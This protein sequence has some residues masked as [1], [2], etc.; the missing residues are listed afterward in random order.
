MHEIDL[1]R[2]PATLSDC[3]REPIHMPGAILPHGVMLVLDSQSMTVLQVAGDTQGLFDLAGA[4]LIGAGIEAIFPA[5]AAARVRQLCADQNI[6]KPR[7]LLDPLLRVIADRPVDASV[8]RTGDLLVIEFEP[9]EI[10]EPYASDPLSAVQEMIEGFAASPSIADLCQKAAER[11]RRVAKYDRV[12]V[13]RFMADASGWVI[14][15]ARR[16]DMPPFLDLH[17]PATDIPQQARALYLQNWLRLITQ[18]DYEPAPLQPRLNPRTGKG[19][20]MSQAIL[21]DVSPIH[22]QYLRNMGIEAS[23]SIS[24]IVED[25]LWGLIACHHDSPRRLP[26]HL[27]AVCEL[28]GAMFSLQ[29]EACERTEMFGARLTSRK[30]LQTL[31]LNL[32][33]VEDY[34]LGLTQHSPDLLDYIQAGTH[35][36]DG[37]R[38]GGVAVFVDGNLTVLGK[39]PTPDQMTA[40][41]AWLTGYMAE[42]EG[43]LATDRLGEIWPPA[44]K[45]AATCSG[46]LVIS[47]SR[48]PSDFIMWFRPELVETTLWGGNPEKTAS[49]GDDGVT[50]IPRKSFAAWQ[51]TVRGRAMPWTT[52][53]TDAAFDLRVSLLE[54]VLRRIKAAAAARER[55]YDRDKLLMA[56]L[57]HRVKNTL[58][59]IQSLVNQASR[60]AQSLTGF[61]EGLDGRIQSMAKAHSL[62]TQSRWEGVS[63]EG[64]LREE[65]E[66]YCESGVGV[67][68][69]GT[70]II[71]TPKAALALSLVVH[72]LATNAAKFGA[73]SVADGR[74]GVDWRLRTDGGVTL[75]WTESR[76]PP[77]AV[78]S[79][80]GFGSSLIERAL[81]LETGGEAI[82]RYEPSGVI[83]EIGLPAHSVVEASFRPAI[84]VLRPPEPAVLPAPLP[85]RP[86][87]LVVEDSIFVIMALETMCEKLGW[88]MIGPATR[89]ADGLRLARDETF[90]AALLD[91]NLDGDMSWDI[92]ALLTARGIPFAFGTGYDVNNILPAEF[93]GTPIF[94][95]PFRMIEVERQMGLLLAQGALLAQAGT[96]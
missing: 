5:A 58:A 64:L 19:L 9:A 31:M 47:V 33:G 88:D 86:R 52:S 57:D 65:L 50:L 59:N 93:A 34:A 77:V 69:T 41:T 38:S 78:P 11:V 14:A 80:R 15:E 21:R 18:V 37:E 89:V 51:Q 54:V 7:H 62:L 85:P 48:E 84:A 28:F 44:R 12:M 79:R 72:E 76:G 2:A 55:A 68:F 30:T 53:E 3:D 96:D 82:V 83:C 13:Y 20:D 10:A 91:V 23:M 29:L 26:R 90:D 43:I 75:V 27:R 24:I 61:V 45:F 63:I 60:S 22:R 87:V 70:E 40:L 36:P 81:A 6:A 71:L 32:A 49:V 74:V 25:R 46:L 8:H 56:E 17:Y 39:T 73:F 1:A 94:S 92:A 35:G 95:K 66:P 16:P 42:F 4:A 67:A